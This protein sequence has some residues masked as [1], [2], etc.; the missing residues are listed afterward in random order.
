MSDAEEIRA[1]L[2][3]RIEALMRRDAASANAVLDR[4]LVA[5][6]VAGPLQLPAAQ[7][8][9]NALTQGWLD[10]FEEGPKISMC[11]VT[12]LADGIVAF[13]HNMTRLQGRRSD[14]QEVDVT[15]RSTLGLQKLAGEWKIVHGHTSVPR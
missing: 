2:D 6:E 13:C 14:G 1:L 12:I 5:F 10:S 9:D 4:N 15:M 3:A 7:A 11:E 8:T